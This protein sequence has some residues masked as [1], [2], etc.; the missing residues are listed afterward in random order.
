V[1]CRCRGHHGDGNWEWYDSMTTYFDF[2][3]DADGDLEVS[4]IGELTLLTGKALVAQRLKCRFASIQGEWFYD[5]SWGIDYTNQI[6]VRAPNFATVRLLL[7]DQVTECPGVRQVTKF[8]L[9][10]DKVTSELSLDLEVL[11]DEGETLA[12]TAEQADGAYFLLLF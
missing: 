11:T 9:D 2:G 12:A 5:S 1:P 6:F 7:L 10:Y 3:L 8:E 4:D